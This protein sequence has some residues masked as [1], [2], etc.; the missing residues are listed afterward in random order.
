MILL[1]KRHN[2]GTVIL[3]CCASCSLGCPGDL[4]QYFG[5][6]FLFV[7]VMPAEVTGHG[8]VICNEDSSIPLLIQK[9]LVML[10]FRARFKKTYTLLFATPSEIRP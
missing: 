4:H 1:K 6:L 9:S 2:I 5:E 8:L 10:I 3:H 7:W